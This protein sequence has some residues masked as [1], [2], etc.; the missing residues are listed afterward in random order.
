MK[1]LFYI[2]LVLNISLISLYTGIGISYII[3][4]NEEENV[5][6]NKE[7]IDIKIDDI[8]SVNEVG[9]N[10]DIENNIM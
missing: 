6:S 10:Y 9:S 8:I 2:L 5:I 7:S 4:D 3:Y 1:K